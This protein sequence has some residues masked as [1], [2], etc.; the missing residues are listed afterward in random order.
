MIIPNILII[1]NRPL[2]P[3]LPK[4]RTPTLPPPMPLA[5]P[6]RPPQIKQK[7]AFHTQVT[8]LHPSLNYTLR[9]HLSFGK[10]CQSL[11]FFNPAK[12]LSSNSPSREG[13]HS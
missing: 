9:L 6:N 8:W 12:A 2:S 4:P 10:T 5:I 1:I 11:P 7:C 13:S 3:P